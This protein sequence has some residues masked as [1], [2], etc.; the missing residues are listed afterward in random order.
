[1]RV[2]G[3]ISGTSF[4][5]IEAAAVD[6]ELAGE[7]V[8]ARVVATSS[9]P[10]APELRARIAAALPPAATTVD[11]I[12]ALDTLI[13]QAFAGA[14]AALEL[15]EPA[16]LVC[17][18]GQTVY[19]WVDGRDALGT[20]QLG[21]PAWLAERLG[22]PVVSDV[23]SRDIAAGG[24]GAPL[25]SILDVLL[26]GGEG[27]SCAAL[28]LGGIANVTVIR[29]GE[30]PIAYDTGPANALL[31]L[32]MARGGGESFDRDGI[33]ARRG[34]VDAALLER[35]LDEPY[36]AL[37][38]PKTTGKELFHAAY[39]DDVDLPLDDLLATLVALTVE[40]V[41]HELERW[42]VERVV[43]SGGGARNPA[44]IDGLA[45]RLREVELVPFDEL[46]VPA[47]A[48]EAVV[49]ALIGFLTAH[50]L[51]GAVPSCTGA[52]RA[53]VLGTITPGRRP[54]VLPEPAS[55]PPRRLVLRAAAGA[56]S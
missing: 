18:H 51:P 47:E 21:Q 16:Q 37:L 33:R 31:D 5:A 45:A 9:T 15:D 23:R 11:E 24:Q 28:N 1:M 22:V 44:I 19:H 17:S 46:G 48:K 55:A 43:V 54:L 8:S 49:F 39:L 35:L 42:G 52:R 26:L 36:Y 20:L 2:I 10:Y 56:P 30:E 14:A 50:G 32:A 53:A 34:R 25:A 12:C 40:T 13:G 41:A 38:P 27:R 4:D 29:P 6:F 3:L 7:T